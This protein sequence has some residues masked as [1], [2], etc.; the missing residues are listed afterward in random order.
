MVLI[1]GEQNTVQQISCPIVEQGDHFSK[2][3]L[4]LNIQLESD[5]RYSNEKDKQLAPL[6]TSEKLATKIILTK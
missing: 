6:L 3:Q 2:P 1:N 4:E 5:W